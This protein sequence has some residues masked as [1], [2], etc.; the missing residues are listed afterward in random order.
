MNPEQLRAAIATTTGRP[1]Q[2]VR[3]DGL[4]A[5]VDV[6]SV[7]VFVRIGTTPTEALDRLL[8]AVRANV[9]LGGAGRAI[10]FEA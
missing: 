10:R 1:V 9:R 5:S 4:Q 6:P 2:E 8:I 3:L 7:G